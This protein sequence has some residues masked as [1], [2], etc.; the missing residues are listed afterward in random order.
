MIDNAGVEV[1]GWEDNQGVYQS[2]IISF[3]SG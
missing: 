3:K 2:N 1:A